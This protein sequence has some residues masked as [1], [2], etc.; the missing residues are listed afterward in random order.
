MHPSTEQQRSNFF[1][2]SLVPQALSVILALKRASNLN[3]TVHS[4]GNWKNSFQW[5]FSDFLCA[6]SKKQHEDY[7]QVNETK[8]TRPKRFP[9]C[10]CWQHESIRLSF[11]QS[12]DSQTSP[13][14]LLPLSPNLSTPLINGVILIFMAGIYGVVALV[15]F[16][17]R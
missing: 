4:P 12:S 9:K 3:H 17:S 6:Q 8:H 1:I 7:A 2:I 11:K 15:V 10:I 5:L 16:Q 13:A 14:F